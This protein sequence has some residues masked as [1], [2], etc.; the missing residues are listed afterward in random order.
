MKANFLAFVLVAFCAVSSSAQKAYFF[1]EPEP[2]Y[3]KQFWS[4]YHQYSLTNNKIP[5][6]FT[7]E[8]GA[9]CAFDGFGFR[10]QPQFLCTCNNLDAAKT[11]ATNKLWSGGGLGLNLSGAGLNKLAVWDG[12][13]ARTSHIELVGRVVVVDSPNTLSSHTSAVVGNMVASGLNP[14]IR[15]MSYQSQLR[16][17]NFSNDNA[18]IIGA[19][20]DL[21]LSNHSYASTTAWTYIGG[22]LYWFGDSTLNR[23]KDWKFGY[24]DNRSRIWDS[25]MVQNPYYLMVKAAG[26]D[27]GSGVAPGTLHYYWKD[28]A[29]ALSTATRDTVGPYDCISTFGNAKNILTIGAVQIIPTGYSGPSSVNMLSYSSWGPTDD[30]RIKPDLVGASGVIL[31]VGSANDS[32]YAGLGGTSMSS[33]NVCGSLLLLQQYR[34]QLKGNY[35]RNATLKGL[36]IHTA[37]RCK[38]N[39]GPD[40]EC[41]WG[42]PNMAK[43]ASCLKDSIKNS[44]FEASLNNNDSFIKEVFVTSGDSLRITMVWTDPKAPTT[45]PAYNDTTPKLVNDL[46]I[47]L[48]NMAGLV[49]GQPYILNPANPALAATTGDNKRDNV[50][51]IYTTTLPTGRYKIKVK[52]KGQLQ[53]QLAQ[54]FSLL[55]SGA[56]IYSLALPVKWLSVS[57]NQTNWNEAEVFWSTTTEINNK[58]F[59]I[60]YSFD[61]NNFL[62]AG[63]IVSA[64]PNKIGLIQ[65]RFNHYLKNGF[66]E[67]IFYRIK[68]EDIDGNFSYSKTISLQNSNPWRVEG[69]YPN[70]FATNIWVNITAQPNSENTFYLLD[71]KGQLLLQE[72]KII[73]GSQTLNFDFEALQPGLYFIQILEAGGNNR[74]VQKLVKQ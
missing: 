67:T 68:Q 17:W 41:G 52:H 25:V 14:N 69:I 61:G 55:I 31:S 35:M 30:G 34:H 20:P 33:P 5:L 43:A 51:Q 9:D 12:G 13:A 11:I 28:T 65:Y 36:A 47:R 23:L 1:Y 74:Y 40:Y 57:A 32:A 18:E 24:Y 64:N 3:S 71:L 50:E 45:A 53:G 54:T 62:P 73:S 44:I 7:L 21:F 63:K 49:L 37:D 56:P 4:E 70:P 48:T 58:E 38:A 60:E 46:D 26:N 59:I 29:W 42:L 27:R 72:T 10:G 22:S 6:S 39:P 15:G 8:N 19:A 66:P 16:N 2:N